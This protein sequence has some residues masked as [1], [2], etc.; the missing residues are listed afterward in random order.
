MYV[1]VSGA[2]DFSHDVYKYPKLILSV[3]GALVEGPV[4]VK[5]ADVVGPVEAFDA[6]GH[7]LQV[8]TFC[9]LRH[10][11]HCKDLQI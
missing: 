7:T 9:Q 5:A 3:L 11:G 8:W 2:L 10:R 6:L 4:V 1:G